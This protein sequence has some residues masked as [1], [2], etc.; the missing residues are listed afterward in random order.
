MTNIMPEWTKPQSAPLRIAILL[1][2]EFSNLCLANSV[3]PLRAANT[4]ARDRVF[5]WQIATLDGE[6]V[7][8]S[9]GLQVVPHAKLDNGSPTDAVFV[10]A[11]YGYERHDTPATRRALIAASRK[12][13]V[14]VGLDAAPWLLA[15]AGLLDGRRATLH[16][17]VL[18]A[19]SERFL[20]VNAER[21][22]VVRDGPFITCAG[23]ISALDLSLDL[24]EEH[25]GLAARLDVE[26]LFIRNSFSAGWARGASG[27][28]LVMRALA[29][30]REN[31]ETPL[32]LAAL[33]KALSCQPR[34]LDRRFRAR[35]GA[36]PGRVYRHQRLVS[37]RNML[38]HGTLG[39]AEVSVRCG[40]ES[41]A[42][43]AR[44]IRSVYGTTPSRLRAGPGPW[45]Q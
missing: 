24:V 15:S 39:I 8:S 20:E 14:T 6:P 4:I 38:E 18:D 41:P 19:F 42:A 11:S 29:L 3:E 40:Y 31:V 27:D 34:T 23:A 1:F 5:D 35:L 28:S 13:K 17:D 36:P 32:S 30:M 44:A 2:D 10:L 37:A 21:A 16:W 43:L 7:R 9:S 25:R 26:A 33:A 12:A 45:A 22:R